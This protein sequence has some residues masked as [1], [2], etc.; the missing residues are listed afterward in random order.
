MAKGSTSQTVALV[1]QGNDGTNDWY[2][3]KKIDAAETVN[4]LAIKSALSLSSDID[5]SAC[6]IWLEITDT[7]GMIYAIGATEVI[8]SVEITDID[9]PVSNTALDNEAACVTTGVS[10]TTPSVKWTP[11]DSTAGYN[12]SYT[13]SITLTADT[14][15]EFIDS[16][17]ATVL[18]NTATSVTKNADGTLTVTYTFSAT[19]KRVI[20]SVTAPKVPTNNIFTTYYGYEG[21]DISPVSGSNSELGTQATVTFTDSVNP[22]TEAMDVTWSIAN[23]GG[24]AYDQ[25]P[26][27]KNTFRWTIPAEALTNYSATDCQGYDATTGT[28]TGTVAITNKDYTPVTITGENVTVTYH[29]EDTLDVSQFFTIDENAGTPT[30]ELSDTSTGAGTLEGATLTMTTLGTFVVKVSTPI[31]GVYNKGEH[32]LT[33]TV[34]KATPYIKTAPTATAITYGKTL[35]DA[36]LTGGSVQ[37]SSEDETA[38]DGSFAWK[39]DT[40]K[41]AVADSN[42]TTYTVVFTPENKNY[43]TVE[44]DITVTVNKADA[45]QNKPNNTMNVDYSKEKVSDITLPEGWAWQDAYKEKTLTV[46]TAVAATAV[47]TGADKGNFE[48]E[49]VEISITRQKCAHDGETEVVGAVEATCKE[50]GFTG[51]I[52]C[53]ACG[54]ILIP[55]TVIDKLTT[56]S[57]VNGVCSVCDDIFKTT[58]DGVTYQVMTE[59]G[60]DGKPVGKL[61][62]VSGNEIP[63]VAVAVIGT[64]DD[65]AVSDGKVTVPSEITGSGSEQTFV[66]TKLSEN[67]FSGVSVTEIIVPATVTEVGTG[68]FGTA[69]TITFKGNTAPSGIAG[70]ITETVTTVNV[71]EGAADSYREELDENANIVEVHTHTFDTKWTYDETYHWHVATCGHETEVSDKA[72]HTF[73]EWVTVTEATEDAEG[74]KERSCSCGYKETAKID[75]LAHTIHVKDTG[76][77]V[78]PTCE[79]KGSIT[80][81]CTKCGEVMEVEELDAT[82][83]KWDAGKVTKEATETAEGVKTYTCSVCGKTKTEA[84]PKKTAITQEPPKKGDVVK[85]DKTSVKVEVTDVAKKEVEYK[86]PVNKKAKTVSIPATV[87]IN[88]VTYKVTKIA[89]NAFKN[90]KTVTKVT[91]G[92]NIKSIGK[93]AF[94]KCTKLK[95]VKIGKNVTEVGANAFKGCSSLTSVTL[96]SKATK[97]GANAFSGCKKLK[98]IKITSTKLTSKTVSKNAF[99]GLTKATTIKVP[100]KKLSAYKKLF[101]QKGLSSKVTVKG[102]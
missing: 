60:A 81:K 90:N 16:T 63:Q 68:A 82:G 37:Y 102:Y 65:F 79:K 62:T 98:T 3:S 89:D 38:V 4:A 17:T 9:T 80:Y 85:D 39:V 70:A 44:T 96:P 26:G 5:L 42:T 74:V 97:I 36:T 18:G 28:I 14:G 76:T 56:H 95:T 40:T 30:Y 78:E 15:Y 75:K 47:Y 6:K 101:K 8:T 52:I 2:Y 10:S 57:Y 35:A 87:K 83:H 91:V 24:A 49:S 33:I 94:Y 11:N 84:I 43:N 19:A 32:T 23:A 51:D 45:P 41:P 100:K 71:P 25:T 86:E 55:G 73:G 21:Y 31:N 12:T 48:T 61:V 58:V 1:V 93:N 72:E 59:T 13:A 29:G 88:G 54:G 50:A 7:D 77:R 66:V 20:G 22:N 27:A 69:S 46:G 53:K 67:A 99:K 64:G 34:N 92:S